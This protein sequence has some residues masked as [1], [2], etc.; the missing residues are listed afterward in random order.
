[1]GENVVA[2]T[3]TDYKD[4][5]QLLASECVFRNSYHVEYIFLYVY[6]FNIFI[7]FLIL[8]YLWNSP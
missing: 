6:V 5:L 7:D 3:A 4:K 8:K 2:A 1:M